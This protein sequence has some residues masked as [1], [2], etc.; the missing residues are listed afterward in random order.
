MQKKIK[1]ERNIVFT[2]WCQLL[3]GLGTQ[4]SKLS[5]LTTAVT[6]TVYINLSAT[7]FQPYKVPPHTVPHRHAARWF[8]R[9]T[10]L[11][12]SHSSPQMGRWDI[13]IS[14]YYE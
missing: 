8:L 2:L 6:F 9:K 12:A 1:K 14:L 11:S 4:D 7:V 13:P 10:P 3:K 5:L